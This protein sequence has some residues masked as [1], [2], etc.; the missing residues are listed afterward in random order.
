[1]EKQH[2]VGKA[3]VKISSRWDE[4]VKLHSAYNYLGWN[5]LRPYNIITLQIFAPFPIHF[6]W[7]LND[8]LFSSMP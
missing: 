2:L 6:N 5:V 1:M 4:A 3:H 8:R 7:S